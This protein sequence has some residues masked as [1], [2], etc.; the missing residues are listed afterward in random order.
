MRLLSLGENMKYTIKPLFVASALALTI[1]ALAT[2]G[3][4]LFNGNL[5]GQEGGAPSMTAIDPTT[6]NFFSTAT[7]YGATRTTY[8]T[9]GAAGPGNNAGLN[10]DASTLVSTNQYT[11]EM[12]VSFANATGWRKLADVSNRT[13]DAGLYISP[14]SN[15]DVYPNIDGTTPLSAQTYYYLATSVDASGTV[16]GYVNG[17]LEFTTTSSSLNG[18]VFN[19]FVDDSITSY[20]E[21]TK[22]SVGLIRLTNSVLTDQQI[23]NQSINPYSAPVPEPATFAALS[24]GLGALI[25]RRK[26]SN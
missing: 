16:K 17:N 26:K 12:V 13:S 4:Y 3:T 21:Y 19:F 7:I 20:G 11:L 18:N 9:V 22:V 5:N 10:L 8:N 6:S 23:S 14:S 2:Q 24:L 25:I 15:L 1:S